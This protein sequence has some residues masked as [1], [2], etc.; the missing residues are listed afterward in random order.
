MKEHVSDRACLFSHRKPMY[1]LNQI[2]VTDLVTLPS[3]S[4]FTRFANR[5]ARN[6]IER[7][8]GNTRTTVLVWL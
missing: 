2:L 8:K 4:W 3:Q 5:I 1:N 6:N 7:G